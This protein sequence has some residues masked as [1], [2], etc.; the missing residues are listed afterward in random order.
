MIGQ[1]S[2]TALVMAIMDGA[3]QLRT[4]IA[5]S[6]QSARHRTKH[7]LIALFFMLVTGCEPG[8]VLLAN[9]VTRELARCPAQSM[10]ARD[11]SESRQAMEICAE[12]YEAQGYVRVENLTNEQRARLGIVLPR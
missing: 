2:A 10:A 7:V 5:R 12:R 3:S 1:P 9:P 11:S 4:L 8:Y 6:V